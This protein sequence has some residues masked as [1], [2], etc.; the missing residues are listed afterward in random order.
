MPK[1]GIELTLEGAAG[2]RKQGSFTLPDTFQWQY[3]TYTITEKEHDYYDFYSASGETGTVNPTDRSFSFVLDSTLAQQ[4]QLTVTFA[5][6]QKAA[7]EGA[8][9]LTKTLQ[10]GETPYNSTDSFT[11]KV[12]ESVEAI[13]DGRAITVRAD[14]QAVNIPGLKLGGT[15]FIKE[16][17]T[18]ADYSFVNFTGEGLEDKG[19]GVYQFTVPSDASAENVFAITAT[20]HKIPRAID[21]PIYKY[22]SNGNSLADAGF[23]LYAYEESS[24]G[25]PVVGAIIRG[26][27][28]TDAQG[29]LTISGLGEG[30]YIL[31]ETRVPSGHYTPNYLIAFE[32]K[33]NNGI[34]TIEM[35]NSNSNF[36]WED[37]VLNIRNQRRSGGGGGGDSGDDDDDYVTIDDEDVP[38]GNVTIED[39]QIPLAGLPDA[40]G[41]PVES[42]AL[43]GAGMM[44]AGWALGRKKNDED[45]EK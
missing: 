8:V 26:E 40:G 20:N 31:R 24:N 45:A 43:I 32:V 27:Q 18:G 35:L 23:T 14:G 10:S 41:F 3:G 4:G 36:A 19:N 22:S 28:T 21:L 39:P 33:Y 9:T 37:G 12:A 2:E 29:R 34:L 25:N 1:A 15:Y 38:L 7:E 13:E 42:L 11:F 16:T 6:H 30:R 44:L 5:N 17:N